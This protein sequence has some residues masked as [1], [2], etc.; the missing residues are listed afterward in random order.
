LAKN[1]PEKIDKQ[2]QQAF[3]RIQTRKFGHN[4]EMTDY[5]IAPDSWSY[6]EF[7]TLQEGDCP[8]G[9]SHSDGLLSPDGNPDTLQEEQFVISDLS[10]KN[11]L[12]MFF[13]S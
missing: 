3:S 13:F 10:V 7:N 6:N 4:V 12:Q 5:K 9:R 2:I 1:D 8:P 11:R